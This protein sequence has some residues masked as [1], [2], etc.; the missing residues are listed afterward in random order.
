MCFK[1]RR[2]APEILLREMIKLQD[3]SRPHWATFKA[4]Y[5]FVH[6]HL[7]EAAQLC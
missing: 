1:Y 5:L 6:I 7:F 4:A 3:V 2:E